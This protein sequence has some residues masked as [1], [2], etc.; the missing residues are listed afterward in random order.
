MLPYW[1]YFSAE[2]LRDWARF[3]RYGCKGTPIYT[4]RSGYKSHACPYLDPY[5][6]S[7]GVLLPFF[8]SRDLLKLRLTISQIG[9]DYDRFRLFT[10]S[11]VGV[12]C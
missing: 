6:R 5:Y 9:Q 3:S 1:V 10:I 11:A 4:D 12:F 7:G 2:T 8:D